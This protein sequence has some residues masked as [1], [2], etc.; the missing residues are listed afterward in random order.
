MIP[1]IEKMLP[2]ESDR[3]FR[4]LYKHRYQWPVQRGQRNWFWMR[5]TGSIR[6]RVNAAHRRGEV[7]VLTE[8]QIAK[9]HE[10]WEKWCQGDE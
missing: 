7:M 4:E 2:E 3:E 9:I 6:R 5:F 1:K 8:R 10:G